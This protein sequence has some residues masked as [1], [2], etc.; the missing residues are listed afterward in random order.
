MDITEIAYL[1][2][3]V[4]AMASGKV[5]VSSIDTLTNKILDSITNKVGADHIHLKIK[6]GE[7]L[8][9]GDLVTMTGYN[10]GEDAI[11]VAKPTSTEDLVMGVIHYSLS[12]GSFGGV[13]ILGIYSPIN[14]SNFSAKDRLYSDGTGGFTN[15]KPTT[16]YYQE[17]AYCLKNK[18]VGSLYLN[19]T[20]PVKN[21]IVPPSIDPAFVGAL[22]NDNGT[23]KISAG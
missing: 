5:G 11:I 9:A 21:Y 16:E 19:A 17:L 13:Q 7:D 3:Q 6:A 2:E 8:I 22:W 20:S 14:L 12:N 23:L 1:K 18:T 4:E 15:V 10:A